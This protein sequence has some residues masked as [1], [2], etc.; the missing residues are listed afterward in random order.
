[1]NS[2]AAHNSLTILMATYEGE[3]FID[4]QIES[5]TADDAI[6]IK[7]IVSDD[8]KSS[9]TREAL[10]AKVQNLPNLDVQY[11]TG[12]HIGFVENFTSLILNCEPETRFFSFSDQDDIWLNDKNQRSIDWLSSQPDDI[13]ALYCG[14][15]QMI[16]KDGR[17]IGRLSPLFTRRPAFENALV[18]SIAG[19]NTM[20]MNRAAFDL[21]KRSLTHGIPVSHDW[22]AYIMVAG[23]GGIIKYDPEPLTLYRQH[24]GNIIGENSSYIARA[25][26]FLLVMDG[27]WQNWQSKHINLLEHNL[28]ELNVEANAS[29]QALKRVR[30]PF[31][32]ARWKRLRRSGVWRQT[33]TGTISLYIASL[34]NRL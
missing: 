13:P 28:G 6:H 21:I 33:S 4:Q 8:S 12:P 31:W 22:W 30:R 17:D 23:A 7:L 24:G 29:L 15:T 27:T 25:K 34:L 20:T 5:F 1:M 16:D 32:L 18:Q 19:G 14:R 11:E 26:R 2:N 9:G 10:F 3:E